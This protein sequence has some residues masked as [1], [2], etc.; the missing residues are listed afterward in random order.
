MSMR[1]K[2][3][4]IAALSLWMGLPTLH[5]A[6]VVTVKGAQGTPG[7]QVTVEVDLST[8]AADVAAAE[9]R[10]P[11]P[12]GVE[13]VADSV[14]LNGSRLSGH[15]VTADMNGSDFVIVLFNTS[16][17]TIPAG[18]GELLTFKLALGDNPGH[19][20]LSP[21]VKLSGSRGSAIASQTIDGTLSVLAPRLE[22]GDINVDFGRVPLQSEVVRQVEVRNSGTTTLHLSDYTVTG[23]EGLTAVM[24]QSLAEGESAWIELHYR[25]TV[26]SAGIDGRFIPVSDGVGR[27]QSVR[28]QAVP[29]SVNE[30]HVGSATG[31]S[32]E[33]V[34]VSVS[35]NNMEPIAGADFTILLPEELEFVEGSILKGARASAL[36]VENT[37]GDDRSL[38]IVMFGL[39]NKA[40]DGNEGELLSFRLK[41]KGST[42]YYSLM[43]SKTVLANAA[44]ENMTS[45]VYGGGIQISSPR[46][47]ASSDWAIGNVP[48]SGDNK[49]TF[50]IYNYGE[51]PLTVEKVVFLNDVAECNTSFPLVMNPYEGKDISISVRKPQF[52]EFATT[53][54]IYCNDPD[55]RMKSVNV[56][57]NFYSPNELSFTGRYTDGKFY[58]DASLI[59]E[60]P[61]AA[62]Q[63]D[64]VCP[65]GLSTDESLLT[66]SD[67]A[68]AHS[69]TLAKVGANR[70]RVVIF[71]LQ[72][73]TF[74]GNDGILFSLGI[75]GMTPG[76]K[77]IRIE[78]IKLSSVDG[79]NITTPDSEIKLG[80]LP[81]PVTT[82]KLSQNSATIRVGEGLKLTATFDPADAAVPAV[83]WT[84]SDPEVANVDDNGN[85]TAFSIGTARITATAADG[86]GISAYCEITVE[87][88]LVEAIDLSSQSLNIQVGESVSLTAIVLPEDATDKAVIWSSSDESVATVDANGKVTALALG[89]ATITASCGEA[90]A[91]CAVTVV[92]TEVESIQ[93]D[94]EDMTVRLGEMSQLTVTVYPDDATDKRVE[95]S[96]SDTD[97]ATVDNDGNV[98]ATG[99]GTTEII[100]TANNGISDRITV[101]V[102]A[103]LAISIALSADEIIIS[104]VGETFLLTATVAPMEASGQSL[105]WTSSDES[106]ATVSQE[107]TVT[108]TGI[109]DAVITVSTTDGSNLSATCRILCLL[110]LEDVLA[111]LDGK[112]DVYTVGGIVVRHGCDLDELENLAPGLYIVRN[113]ATVRTVYL[114]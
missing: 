77:Q 109:G 114:R 66:L 29:F 2:K 48:L 42:G 38:R 11:L 100:A 108:I 79:V 8:D 52:G 84:S 16:L 94:Q 104:E 5:A 12:D 62:L 46:L 71:S 18:D 60:E 69:A 80:D 105:E 27:A 58:I 67:R 83:E 17:K 9:I 21:K 14:T 55:N 39:N 85:V 78:N 111:D 75:E 110:S 89:N 22:L 65:E 87:A 81:I 103:P 40:V 70:Y 45:Q 25:P 61:I 68:A 51:V 93:I 35:M 95:W 6:N 82:I 26:R 31:V 101:T 99:I 49:F 50:P 64:V 28:I 20:T 97:V 76:G 47:S 37:V 57:G 72:N 112:V 102:I 92:A 113:G 74:E 10:V 56:T 3:L 107:G 54:N 33:E 34:T 7:E 106:I 36:S 4:L 44:G 86:S 91:T 32:Y 30:L 63:L 73:A 41:L 23:V 24:P 59:N 98:T 88:I 1:V 43:P 96:S 19:F 90:T 53:M 15:S 13:P